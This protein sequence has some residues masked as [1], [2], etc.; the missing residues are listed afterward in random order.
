MP[1]AVGSSCTELQVEMP[2]QAQML[3]L[4]VGVLLE[5]LWNKCCFPKSQ[6]QK[7]ASQDEV[8]V[9]AAS[10]RRDAGTQQRCWEKTGGGRGA[11]GLQRKPKMETGKIGNLGILQKSL[12]EREGRFRGG[13]E[14][15]GSQ[16]NT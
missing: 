7:P 15:M 5:P 16:R 4:N 8:R 6:A 1:F 3:L 14:M 12:E 10:V 11:R 2:L 13:A 9:G